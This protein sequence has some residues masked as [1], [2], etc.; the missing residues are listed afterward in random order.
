[1]D[2]TLFSGKCRRESMC[3]LTARLLLILPEHRSTGNSRA[4]AGVRVQKTK[5]TQGYLSKYVTVGRKGKFVLVEESSDLF[6]R[7]AE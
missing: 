3:S 2:F 6:I 1:M 5:R 7:K 4:S